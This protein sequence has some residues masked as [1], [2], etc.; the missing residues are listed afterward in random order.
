[1]SSFRIGNEGRAF[2]TVGSLKWDF[3]SLQFS[4][5]VRRNFNFSAF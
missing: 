2:R 1:M 4:A 3:V 5:Q